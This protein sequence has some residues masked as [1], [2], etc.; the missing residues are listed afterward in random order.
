MGFILNSFVLLGKLLFPLDFMMA[1]IGRRSSCLATNGY[2]YCFRMRVPHDL[3]RAIGRKVVK[4]SLR[5]DLFWPPGHW[6]C[7][8]LIDTKNGSGGYGAVVYQAKGYQVGFSI[9]PCRTALPGGVS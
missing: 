3:N 2:S 9:R 4:F 1:G 8:G 5:T 6:H 7:S